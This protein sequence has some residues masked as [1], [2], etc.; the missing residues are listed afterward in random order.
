M[1][2]SL[3]HFVSCVTVSCLHLRTLPQGPL[4]LKAKRCTREQQIPRDQEL[5]HQHDF[6]CGEAEC[7]WE[8]VG[9]DFGSKVSVVVL[10]PGV[11]LVDR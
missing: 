3:V 9:G 7:D 5:G 10:L 6:R 1:K 2:P 4:S 11:L 8:G